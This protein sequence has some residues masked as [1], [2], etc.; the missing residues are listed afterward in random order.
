MSE[1]APELFAKGLLSMRVALL[2]NFVAPY[3]LPLLERLQGLLGSLRVLISTPMESDREWAPDWGTLEVKVQ[4]NVTFRPVL[5]DKG[6]FLRRLQVHVP[7]D[8]VP[9][10]IRYRPDVLISCELGPRT[11][12]AV[13]YKWLRPQT[14]LLVWCFLSEHSERSWGRSRLLARRLILGA[15]DG[16]LVNGE[17]GARYIQGFGVPD[18]VITRI[19]Q[20]VDVTRYG[21][22]SRTRPEGACTRLVNVGV[23]NPRK[24]VVPFARRLIAWA[25]KNPRPIEIWW[26]GDGPDRAELEALPWPT[27]LTS[28]FLGNV[29]YVDVAGIYAECDLM[30]FP[31]LLDEW[32]MVVNEAMAMGLPVLGSIYSQAVEELVVEGETGWIMDP[33]SEASLDSGIDRALST[34]PAAMAAMRLRAQTRIAGLTPETAAA[35]IAEAVRQLATGRSAEATVSASQVAS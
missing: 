14:K 7:Y 25:V 32:G 12:Q 16:V 1:P 4:R 5:N 17:S 13:F 33:L 6:G 28:R 15:A 31:T 19:N 9:Q 2:M 26:L 24:G 29:P 22:V 10:L 23:M 8:T 20:P 35:R 3:R 21:K 27:T 30:V 18:R 11:L 34:G